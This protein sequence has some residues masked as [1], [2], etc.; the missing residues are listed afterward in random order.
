MK[1]QGYP[2]DGRALALLGALLSL[3]IAMRSPAQTAA[4]PAAD[5]TVELSP[6]VVKPGDDN[7]YSPTET[8]SGTRLRTEAKNVASAMTIITSE[9]LRD[10]GAMNFYDVVDFLPSSFSYGSNE[11]DAT[12]NGLRTGTPF[13]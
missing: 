8:L 4:T 3:C 5:P 10:I 11:G 6:F 2:R 9:L 7:G 1:P 13:Y 12:A